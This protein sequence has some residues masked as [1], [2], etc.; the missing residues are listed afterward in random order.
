M[1]NRIPHDGGAC[2]VKPST[3]VEVFR[4]NPGL[5]DGGEARFFTWTHTGGD[6]DIVEYRIV[7]PAPVDRE[8]RRAVFL[9]VLPA[10]YA[11]SVAKNIGGDG[12][13]IAA[14]WSLADE[15][16]AQEGA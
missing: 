7:H 1:N 3:R 12:R 2:P 15:A 6:Y 13:V 16:I 11:E 8:F 9:A 4:K 5:F 10:I 14:A